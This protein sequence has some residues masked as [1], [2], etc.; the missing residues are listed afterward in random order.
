MK[1]LPPRRLSEL[2][3]EVVAAL[4]E[5]DLQRARRPS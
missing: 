1:N 3:F 2:S 5:N 4:D